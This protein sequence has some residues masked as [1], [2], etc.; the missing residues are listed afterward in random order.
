VPT[1]EENRGWAGHDWSR[2]GEEWSAGWGS[3]AQMWYG[4]L[5]PRL[6]PYLPAGHV[7]EIA[8]GFGRCT[9]HLLPL[10]S[11]L[12][13]VDL[14]Q[15]CVDACRQRFAAFPHARFHGNDGCT[16]GMVDSASV[17]FAFSWDS[18]VHVEEDVMASYLGELAR[19]LKPGAF[20]FLHHSNLAGID[21]ARI[22]NSHWRGRT[23]SAERFRAIA[24]ALDLVCI[25]QELVPWGGEE[26][27]DAL[28]LF[29]RPEPGRPH[30]EPARVS[31]NGGFLEEV[32]RMRAIG[33]LYARP[34]AAPPAGSHVAGPWPEVTSEPTRA[35]GRLAR[36]LRALRFQRA[37]VRGMRRPVEPM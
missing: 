22:S 23:M 1:L 12:T 5:W 29:C 7:L 20:G 10:A 13:G 34:A 8:P 21:G 37:V 33:A 17:D 27:I 19:V 28:T 30:A 6:H 26:P 14:V 25:A 36:V 11:R 4:F 15:E 31:I 3:T 2:G 18:L 9:A 35:V 32:A 24:D 16:L